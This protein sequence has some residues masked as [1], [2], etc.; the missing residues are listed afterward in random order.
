MRPYKWQGHQYLEGIC[1]W[2][3]QEPGWCWSQYALCWQLNQQSIIRS[4]EFY[5]QKYTFIYR[6]PPLSLD[7]FSYLDDSDIL[8]IGL[9]YSS[10]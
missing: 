1:V 7:T 10:V 8:L 2:K 6:F 4:H 9:P 5:V 3:A